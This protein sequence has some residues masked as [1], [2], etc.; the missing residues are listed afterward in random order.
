M[1]LRLLALTFFVGLLAGCGSG[2]RN[3]GT[4]LASTRSGSM[5]ISV[6]WPVPAPTR[7]IPSASKSINVV[8]LGNDTANKGKILA[9]KLLSRPA[10]GET[11]VNIVITVP[12]GKVNLTATAYPNADGT[13]AAQ[14]QTQLHFEVKDSEQSIVSLTMD[15]TIKSIAISPATTNVILGGA[16]ISYV[17]TAK[18]AAG[19]AVLTLPANLQWT[20][21]NAA[22]ATLTPVAGA[23][24]K[25]H[26]VKAGTVNISVKEAESGVVSAPLVVTVT[27]GVPVGPDTHI[28]IADSGNHRVIGIDDFTGKNFTVLPASLYSAHDVAFDTAGRIYVADYPYQLRRYDNIQAKNP[29]TANPVTGASY[30][31]TDTDGHIYYRDDDL[32]IN[33]VDDLTGAGR[34]SFG[35]I[36]SHI[37]QGPQGIAIDAQKRIYVSDGVKNRVHRFDDISGAVDKFFGDGIFDLGGLNG[38]VGHNIAVDSGS[39]VYVADFNN[40]RIVRI[41]PGAFDDPLQANLAAFN[42]PANGANVFKP[43]GIA[44]DSGNSPHIYF[45]GIYQDAAGN[46]TDSAVYRMDD[47]SGANLTRYGTSGS[48]NGQVSYPVSISVR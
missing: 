2:T 15:T 18:D 35:G 16:D 4:G 19:A 10:S 46:T 17:A 37:F 38:G 28:L 20:V 27:V 31:A 47:M 25:L 26:A 41:D 44:V 23:S 42:V 5:R 29:V 9:Q 3:A 40:K 22:V 48:G 13:G 1:L 30:I 11:S 14:A 7:L 8:V 34:L 39:R 45:T 21:D 32:L 12:I 36:N 24:V 43:L 6:Q 33:R